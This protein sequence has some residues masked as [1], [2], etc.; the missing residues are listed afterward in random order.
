MAISA[1]LAE[2]RNSQDEA[3]FMNP[4]D[5]SALS[6]RFFQLQQL[7]AA[8][9]STELDQLEIEA[10][11]LA[12]ELRALLA[13]EQ[14]VLPFL[15]TDAALTLE[16]EELD[17]HLVGQRIGPYELIDYVGGGGMGAVFLA[18]RVDG[19]FDR[20]VALK[21]IRTTYQKT[22]APAYFQRE[23]QI[24]AQ[25][26]HRNIAHLYDGGQSS[27]GRLYFSMEFVEGQTL[28]EACR[29]RQLTQSERLDLFEQMAAAISYAHQQLVLHLDLKPG[30]VLIESNGQVKVVDFG[31]AKWV[32]QLLEEQDRPRSQPYTLAYAAPEQIRREP[33]TTATDIYALGILLYQLLL[34]QLPF[35]RSDLVGQPPS[36]TLVEAHRAAFQLPENHQLSADWALIIKKAIAVEP[37]ARYQTVAQ[38]LE[39]VQAIRDGYPISLRQGEPIYRLRK[40]LQRN[41]RLT[42]VALVGFIGVVSLVGY[43]TFRLQQ[44]RDTA[45]REAAKSQELIQL[46]TDMFASV[47][48]WLSNNDTLPVRYFLDSASRRVANQEIQDPEVAADMS[49]FLSSVYLSLG[50]FEQA[51]ILANGALLRYQTA[52]GSAD[53][54]ANATAMLAELAYNLGAYQRSDS[55]Y[56][57]ALALRRPGIGLSDWGANYYGL[58]NCALEFGAF[59]EADSLFTLAHSYF[60][61][62]YDPPQVDLAGALSGRGIAQR[63]LRN[64]SEAESYYQAALAQVT[65]LYQPPHAELAYLLNHLASLH[66]DQAQYEEAIPYAEASYQQ[67]LAVF[68]AVDIN[69]IASQSNLC[70]IYAKGGQY[71]EALSLRQLLSTRTVT[72]F[73]DHLHPYVLSID[74]GVAKLYNAVGKPDSAL[75]LFEQIL[76]KTTSLSDPYPNLYLLYH[77]MGRA[78]QKMGQLTTARKAYERAITEMDKAARVH[79]GDAVTLPYDLALCL[80]A[81]GQLDAAALQMAQARTVLPDYPELD[82]QNFPRIND[83]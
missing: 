82:Q 48:P 55:L 21:L 13:E 76:A 83:F 42:A 7:S 38:L 70:R 33:V 68:G 62:V 81:L 22:E 29:E 58:A 64:F 28:L 54:R 78:H 40:W 12:K 37:A 17:Q 80:E 59:R 77:G 11:E 63:K 56:Q 9:R 3:I 45:V 20:R 36:E 39:D 2:S 72:Y 19:V 51:E 75:Q 47:D 25:L 46:F 74:E 66:Y 57:A 1:T 50:N 16:M 71:Q 60:D 23:R 49:L 79:A 8:Q 35:D 24:L 31:V 43:Y 69:T 18:Q 30:N 65:Q 52:G 41:R 32:D 44:E 26:R 5:W 73:G 61:Q 14:A 6:E 67:R 53:Q 34:D 15:R 10:P 27:D 4:D